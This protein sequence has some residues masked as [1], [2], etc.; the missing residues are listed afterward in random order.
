MGLNVVFFSLEMKEKKMARRMWQDLTGSPTKGDGDVL[1]PVFDC[2]RNQTDVCNLSQRSCKIKLMN[3]DGRYPLIDSTPAGYKICSACRD[4]WDQTYLTSWWRKEKR[5]LL[6]PAVAVRKYDILN[7][8]G[9]LQKAGKFHLVEFP[10]DSLTVGEMNAYLNN[11]EYYDNF[12]PDVIITDY[13]D[14]FKW[15]SRAEP[16]HSI[17]RIWASHK[18]LAQAKHCL[19]ATASQS[20]T[21][22]SGKKVGKGS[23]AESIEKRRGIDLG[24][25]LNQTP[26]E[27]E[28]GLLYISI[29][30]MRHE[31]AVFSEVAVLQ[32]L[33]IGRP[34]LDS[35]FVRRTYKKKG[36]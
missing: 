23:W 36:E 2:L 28:K 6:D 4:K 22:R 17:D 10:T 12:I 32:N 29:D 11:L 3:D 19:V 27:L 25:A 18:G 13:A 8:T 24:L 26:E 5:D 34:Y 31:E 15:D 20:N 35:C 21:E 33:S 7:R 9:A 16:R 14:K 1:V 30:K